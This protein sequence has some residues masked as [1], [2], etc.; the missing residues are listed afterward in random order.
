[1]L[2]NDNANKSIVM[3][4][5]ILIESEF[6]LHV[7]LRLLGRGRGLRKYN[8][9]SCQVPTP[10]LSLEPEV[11]LTKNSLCQ[12]CTTHKK[13]GNSYEFRLK[14]DILGHRFRII[15]LSGGSIVTQ[16][17]AIGRS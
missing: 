6:R 5:V 4:W 1:M 3:R 17:V 7:I 15:P 12:R 10:R 16:G 8:P 13:L 14:S 2:I 9:L 11:P